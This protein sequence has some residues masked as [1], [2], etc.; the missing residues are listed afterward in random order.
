MRYM[1]LMI[2]VIDSGHSSMVGRN[3]F[4][5]QIPHQEARKSSSSEGAI[6]TMDNMVELK[7]NPGRGGSSRST[8][9]ANR[10]R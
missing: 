6:A 10:D 8:F 5:D 3:K 9:L 1:V 2:E 7:T 4:S